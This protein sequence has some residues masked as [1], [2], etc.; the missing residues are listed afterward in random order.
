MA[1]LDLDT[2]KKVSGLLHWVLMKKK[3]CLDF[4]TTLIKLC[5]EYRVVLIPSS[6]RDFIVCEC[7]ALLVQ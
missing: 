2:R 7:F 1:P 4:R 6:F 3:K 5:S